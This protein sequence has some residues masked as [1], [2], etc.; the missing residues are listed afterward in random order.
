M[1]SRGSSGLTPF[2]VTI[3]LI[4]AIAT[5]L[6]LNAASAQMMHFTLN[7]SI[8]TEDGAELPEGQVCVSGEVDPICQDVGGNPSGREFSF[9]GLADGPHD[10][11]IN[12]GDYLEIVDTVTLTED[13]TNVEYTLEHEQTPPDN[14]D[15]TPAE[16]LP[17]TGT[18][19]MASTGGS[20]SALLLGVGSLVFAMLAFA[21]GQRRRLG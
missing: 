12:A 10:V 13:T 17:E 6:S 1:L 5:A 16:V 19:A 9:P 2:R 3:V 8:F 18:G 4:V 15:D 21:V 14:G 11:T 7:I 20:S